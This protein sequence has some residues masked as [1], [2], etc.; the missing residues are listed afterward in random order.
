LS[1]TKTSTKIQLK[2]LESNYIQTLFVCWYCR[3]YIQY[4]IEKKKPDLR[5]VLTT[6]VVRVLR[7]N[8][9]MRHPCAD[10]RCVCMHWK[11]NTRCMN[12]TWT[13]L[14][15]SSSW[16]I[17]QSLCSGWKQCTKNVCVVRCSNTQLV[18]ALV[19]HALTY[20]HLACIVSAATCNIAPCCCLAAWFP[21]CPL[22]S[23]VT[24]CGQLPNKEVI[25][26]HNVAN[27]VQCVWE[28]P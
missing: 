26:T 24:P 16:L 28:S 12:F 27:F 15:W 10:I 11:G 13:G 14:V 25:M 4:S 18:F 6:T 1:S 9:H 2:Y 20:S 21:L 8:T 19:G 22:F 5:S 3:R 7:K 23:V 17:P